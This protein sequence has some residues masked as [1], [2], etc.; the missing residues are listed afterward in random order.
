MKLKHR[1]NY[2]SSSTKYPNP[3]IFLS[4]LESEYQ[5]EKVIAD[6][7]DNK[8]I[9]L[10]TIILALITV[11]IPLIKYKELIKIF[12]SCDN[13]LLFAFCLLF[14]FVGAFALCL[15]IYTVVKLVSIYRP[16]NYSAVN[17]EALDNNELLAV[18]PA[19]RFQ[20]ELISHYK[21]IILSNSKVNSDK[22]HVLQK[23]AKN[24]ILVFLLFSIYA[25]GTQ[26]CIGIYDFN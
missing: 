23:Q 21:E 15:A 11:Y 22:A 10:V 6:R 26:I 14:T 19:T 18:A 24:T 5:Q 25:I 2:S 16:Q 13:C 17:I 20:M 12:F 7:I 3:P 4:I 1:E 8:S 9:A